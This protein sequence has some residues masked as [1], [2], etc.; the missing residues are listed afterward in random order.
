MT[1]GH[2]GALGKAQTYFQ[3]SRMYYEPVLQEAEKPQMR[4]ARRDL[5]HHFD[6]FSPFKLDLFN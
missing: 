5:A 4:K 3:F 1:T 2:A 6:A